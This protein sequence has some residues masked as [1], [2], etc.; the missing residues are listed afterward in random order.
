[1]SKETT[2][3]NIDQRVASPTHTPSDVASAMQHPPPHAQNLQNL[4]ENAEATAPEKPFISTG[5][6]IHNEITYRGVDWLLNS[7]IG[8]AMTYWTERTKSGNAIFKTPVTNFFKKTLR[9]LLKNEAAVIEGARRGSMFTSIIVG[10]TAIIA[11]MVALE[12]KNNKK[13][14]VRWLDEKIYGEETV[15]NDPK[16]EESYTCIDREPKKNF[17]T[18]MLARFIVLTP[19]IAVT[20]TPNANKLAIKYLYNPIAKGS[21]MLTDCLGIRPR[22]LI[23]R[24]AMELADGDLSK[25]PKMVSD[26]DFIHQTIGFDLGLTFIYSYAHEAVIKGL[27]AIGFKKNIEPEYANEST[28]AGTDHSK[29][30]PCP[31]QPPLT[32]RRDHA[33]TGRKPISQFTDYAKKLDT[34]AAIS[35]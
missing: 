10:G 6:R 26:W 21:R 8:V 28:I 24:G 13:A 5:R 7:T 22:K 32:I 15:K 1:M 31:A 14:C 30:P 34:E 3:T 25:A 11:P 17:T 29:A 35:L 12:N 23:E 20:T 19:M 2:K 18:G 33:H 4:T 16:F 9:P 27:A